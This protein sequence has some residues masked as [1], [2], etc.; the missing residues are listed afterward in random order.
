MSI[1]NVSQLHS[2]ITKHHALLAQ[3]TRRVKLTGQLNNRHPVSH[4]S[5]EIDRKFWKMQP[6]R[7]AKSMNE[8]KMIPMLEESKVQSVVLTLVNQIRHYKKTVLV[9][10]V[11]QDKT[12]LQMVKVVKH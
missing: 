7:N 5:V 1:Q 12:L 3:N 2:L 11:P 6:V 9:K 10:I 4:I 8:H